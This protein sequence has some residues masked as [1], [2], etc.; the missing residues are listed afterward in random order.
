M[1]IYFIKTSD[2]CYTSVISKLLKKKKDGK[3]R[4]GDFRVSPKPSFLENGGKKKNKKLIKFL[5]VQVGFCF[6][7]GLKR[8]VFPV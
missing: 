1:A 4:M 5:T 8:S 2:F 7:A 6:T 3:N